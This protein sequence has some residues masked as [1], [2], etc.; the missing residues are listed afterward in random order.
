M[1]MPSRDIYH[2]I[3]KITLEKAGWIITAA[4][5]SIKY[6]EINLYIDLAADNILTR[7]T[8]RCGNQK[9]SRH[10]INT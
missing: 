9:L 8:N 3:V 4:S 5:L 1:N 2:S 7:R 6:G 10:L